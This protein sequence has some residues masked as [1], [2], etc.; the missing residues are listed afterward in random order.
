MAGAVAAFGV[1]DAV[2]LA[3][4]L[5][6]GR[7]WRIDA[8][9]NGDHELVRSRIYGVLRHPIYCSMGFAFL[10]TGLILTPPLLL[11]AAALAFVVCTDIRVRIEDTLLSRCFGPAFAAIEPRCRPTFRWRGGLR[12]A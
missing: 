10:G 7:Q 6:L 12:N 1:A 8:S 3:S 5:S 9:L 2:C 4:V 11:A